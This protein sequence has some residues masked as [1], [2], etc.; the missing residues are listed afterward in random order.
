MTFSRE[1][2]NAEEGV[3]FSGLT[4]FVGSPQEEVI[5]PSKGSAGTRMLRGSDLSNDDTG[6]VPGI[7]DFVVGGR[8]STFAFYTDGWTFGGHGQRWGPTVR[9]SQSV[10]PRNTRD[11]RIAWSAVRLVGRP[12]TA[13]SVATSEPE[14][15]RT[16]G[17]RGVC[18]TRPLIVP[19]VHQIGSPA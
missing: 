16:T 14:S 11:E 17:Q 10:N 18:R 1:D 3:R 7:W 13:S 8:R 9:A 5:D 15:R 6:K 4:M 12:D 2:C 19:V